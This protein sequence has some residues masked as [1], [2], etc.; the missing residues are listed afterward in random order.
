MKLGRAYGGTAFLKIITTSF[1]HPK[2]H[3]SGG[4]NG[5]RFSCMFLNEVRSLWNWKIDRTTA[6]NLTRSTCCPRSTKFSRRSTNHLTE[7]EFNHWQNPIKH[8]TALCSFPINHRQVGS[9]ASRNPLQTQG[10]KVSLITPKFPIQKAYV[11]IERM[12]QSHSWNSWKCDIQS[13]GW[14][15]CNCD[16]LSHNWNSCNCDTQSRSWNS[17]NCDIQSHGWNS[18]NCDI[19][20]HSWNSWNCDIQSHSWTCDIP[21]HSWI[22]N[23]RSRSWTCDIQN[24]FYVTIVT[25]AS[26]V[27]IG[28]VTPRVT[29]ETDSSCLDIQS[30]RLTS[31]SKVTVG[32][33]SLSDLCLPIFHTT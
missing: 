25:Q 3:H 4:K 5:F 16:I 33:V 27:T 23:I 6:S 20:S 24:Q 11:T 1:S 9:D 28:T 15:S 2:Q 17:W 30:H 22:S 21:S 14:N 26:Q 18:C 19:Q 7:S 32:S 31:E 10:S 13:H 8:R 12:E 29:A